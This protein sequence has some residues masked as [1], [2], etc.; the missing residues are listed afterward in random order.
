LAI[1]NDSAGDDR[2]IDDG[3]SLASANRRKVAIE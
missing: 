1:F 2:A 3:Q